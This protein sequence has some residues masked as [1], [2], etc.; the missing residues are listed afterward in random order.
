MSKISSIRLREYSN[1]NFPVDVSTLV[2]RQKFHSE[3]ISHEKNVITRINSLTRIRPRTRA[4]SST[5][6]PTM[7]SLNRRI[8]DLTNLIR[9]IQS[10]RHRF[11]P[12]AQSFYQTNHDSLR[13]N[14]AVLSV[15]SM[16][17]LVNKVLNAT[18]SRTRCS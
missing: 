17:E 15:L 13:A 8:S 11:G 7:C 12:K 10:A 5:Q 9:N 14:V 3:N 6:L 4:L 1:L 16:P 2:S 18:E